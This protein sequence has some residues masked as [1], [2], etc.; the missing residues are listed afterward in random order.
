MFAVIETGGKQYK[1]SPGQVIEVERLDAPPEE[2]LELDRVLVIST[3]NET[4]LG[5]PLIEKAVVKASVERQGR[6]KKLIIFKFKSK[7]RY[8]RKTGHRQNYTYLKIED[9]LVGGKSF[10]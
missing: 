9:V 10:V 7:K 5:Q 1:V 8:R 4:L 3:E 6:G 2:T